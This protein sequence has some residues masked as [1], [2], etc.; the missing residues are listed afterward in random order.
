L[1]DVHQKIVQEMES[2]GYRHH[3][4]LDKTLATG[5]KV[6]DVFVDPIERQ[7]EILQKKG[8][9]CTLSL[10]KSGVGRAGKRQ[11]IGR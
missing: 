5:I 3:S 8:C 2:R 7:M 4:P 9:S 1:F 11:R 10:Q 6:Q